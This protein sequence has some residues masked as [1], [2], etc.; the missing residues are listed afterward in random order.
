MHKVSKACWIF[1]YERATVI[2]RFNAEKMRSV[3]AELAQQ[4]LGHIPTNFSTVVMPA[5]TRF[6]AFGGSVPP[7]TT[8]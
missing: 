1:N 4:A 5:A 7:A 8:C 3:F 2:M 6:F